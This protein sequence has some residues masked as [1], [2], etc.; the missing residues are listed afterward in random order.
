MFPSKTT[1][2]TSPARFTTLYGLFDRSLSF[3]GRAP[4]SLAP[5]WQERRDRLA[6]ATPLNFAFTG[7]IIGG[8]SGSPVVNRAGDVVGVVFDGNIQSLA[9]EYYYTDETARS[10]AVDSRAIFEALKSVYDART[11]QEELLAAS[12]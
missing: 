2:T 11:L 4:W 12:H 5:R 6:L 7:D 8:N 9:Y 10:V 3:G 1:P